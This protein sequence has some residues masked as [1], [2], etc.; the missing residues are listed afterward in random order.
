MTSPFSQNRFEFGGKHTYFLPRPFFSQLEEAKP[1]YLIGTRGSGKTTLL[2][3]LNWKERL[4]NDTLRRHLDNSPFAARYIGTYVKLPT[5][6][7]RSFEE[8][9]S[10]NET[11][12]GKVVALYLDLIS[13]DLAT[14]A[15]ANLLANGEISLAP[16]TERELVSAWLDSNP[17]VRSHAGSQAC[18]SVWAYSNL[19]SSLR[20]EL[21]DAAMAAI[22]IADVVARF[23]IGQIGSFGTSGF[24]Q[25]AELLGKSGPDV[26][27]RW[28]FKVCMDEGECLT[29][30][31]LRVVNTMFRL[32][33]WPLFPIISFV[34]RPDDITTTLIPHLSQ[35]V[36]DRN[37]IELDSMTRHQ[38]EELAEGVATVRVREQSND[39]RLAFDTVKVLGKLSINALL[40]HIIDK[41]ENP[42]ASE[43]VVDAQAFA[44][45]SRV[46]RGNSA[47]VDDDESPLPIYEAYLRNRL[48]LPLPP[49]GRTDRRREES[50][51][52]RKK[53]VAAYL[54]I[55][56]DLK[57]RHI[58]YAS[59]D[60]VFGAS[61]NCVRD[62]LSQVHELYIESGLTLEVFLES[63]LSIALQSKAILRA[64]EKKRD[65]IPTSGILAPVQTGQIIK[66]LSLLTAA[67][68]STSLDGRHLRSTERGQFVLNDDAASSDKYHEVS[69]A[70]Q[71]AAE[72]GFLRLKKE[73]NQVKYFRVHASLAPAYGFSYRGSYYPASLSID[74][75]ERL[76]KC[77]NSNAVTE[78]ARQIANRLAGE[79]ETLFAVQ[80]TFDFLNEVPM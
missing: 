36:A 43:L 46:D 32:A 52:Y 3:A 80:G 69:S 64:S 1:A 60:V 37:V 74:D 28:H 44:E 47:E 23:P 26:G 19:L 29:E 2:K 54:S 14:K 25:L 70:I 18:S 15:I 72:A 55:C 58:P 34:G 8:W 24:K 27:C 38:F 21:E 78:T 57:V 49:Q 75:I 11:L 79:S 10:P 63:E 51:E 59:A 20:A 31:Q 35:Q 53:M 13:L 6:Q 39:D 42:R 45:E 30:F 76:R 62:Y 71:D 66:G 61:D 67:L 68:Q 73:G 16:D 22:S 9:L 65:S 77:D 41:S 40:T 50:A 17:K 5:I 48:S 56:S 4:E 33:E 12:Y 7:L